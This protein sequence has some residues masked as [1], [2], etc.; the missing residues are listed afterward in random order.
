MEHLIAERLSRIYNEG[1][2]NEVRAL[3]EVSF[4]LEEGSFN[5][6]LG[7]SGAGK[8]TLLNLLGGMDKA[9]SGR[10]L[11]GEEDIASYDEKRLSLYRREDIGFVFQ[12]YNLMEKLTAL[13]NV[14]LSASVAKN[15]LPAKEILDSVGLSKRARNFPSELSGGEQQR[16]AIARAIVKNP[17]F[18][19][20]DE[21]TGAL[22]SRTGGQIVSLLVKVAHEYGKTVVVV[23]HNSVIAECAEHLIRLRD[24][25]VEEDLV[26][27]HPR[28]PEEIE[29]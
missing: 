27:E 24:G 28:L 2:E 5:V 7:A 12:F 19:L 15:P 14:E 16:V 13:E 6:V 26:Q 25:K 10:L 3:D 4:S 17:K 29:L 23:T 1:R 22:D 8:S 20:A 18:L 21:P 9:T 11:L